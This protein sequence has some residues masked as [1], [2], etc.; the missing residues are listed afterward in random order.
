M[1]RLDAVLFGTPADRDVVMLHV[2]ADDSLL[3]T[4]SNF[5]HA[6]AVLEALGLEDAPEVVAAAIRWGAVEISIPVRSS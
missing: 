6:A 4:T 1:I 5:D 2:R 3:M